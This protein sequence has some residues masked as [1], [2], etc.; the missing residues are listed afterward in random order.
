MWLL[1]TQNINPQHDCA[2]KLSLFQQGLQQ[3]SRY[4]GVSDRP[5]AIKL[6]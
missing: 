6:N 1:L 4:P 3:Q 2:A 5:I